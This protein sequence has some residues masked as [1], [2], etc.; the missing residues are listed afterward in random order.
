MASGVPAGQLRAM[1]EHA[2]STGLVS[3][4]QTPAEAG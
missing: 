2:I 1:F 3:G 4:L